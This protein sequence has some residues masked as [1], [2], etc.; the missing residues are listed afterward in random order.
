[1]WSS[2]YL[3]GLFDNSLA[4]APPPHQ[5]P[6]YCVA[7]CSLVCLHFPCR[8]HELARA[9]LCLREAR[10]LEAT[11]DSRS[12]YLDLTLR[13]R[14]TSPPFN[15]ATRLYTIVP[16][17]RNPRAQSQ[18]L[19]VAHSHCADAKRNRFTRNSTE[20]EES[21]RRCAHLLW[22]ASVR[23]PRAGVCVTTTKVK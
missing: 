12:V 17:R 7:E 6:L 22:R 11:V 3:P 15:A 2:A 5:A 13:V 8:H 10:T 14:T 4:G 20:S 9:S 1:M 19:N 16:N 23:P 18:L 21:K